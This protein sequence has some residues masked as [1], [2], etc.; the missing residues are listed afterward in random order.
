M[1]TIISLDTYRERK[2][3]EEL[4]QLASSR[5]VVYISDADIWSKDYE[6]FEDLLFAILK[7]KSIL[8]NN[9]PFNEEWKYYLLNLLENAYLSHE[10]G[11]KE[12]MVDSARTLKGYLV[13]ETNVVNRREMGIGL[14]ILELICKA[15]KQ[16]NALPPRNPLSL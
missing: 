7:L 5:G 3:T 14:V 10:P 13:E 6:N 9:L 4:S 11:R 8:D 2:K 1:S 12:A 15:N 16:R